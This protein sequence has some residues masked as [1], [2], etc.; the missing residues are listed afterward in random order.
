[1]SSTAVH[2]LECMQ[3]SLHAVPAGSKK[4]FAA[5]HPPQLKGSS[6]IP[7]GSYDAFRLQTKLK[8][9]KKTTNN[10]NK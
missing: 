2:L 4:H 9:T 8:I 7:A 3:T 6:A 5:N 1:M 10:N